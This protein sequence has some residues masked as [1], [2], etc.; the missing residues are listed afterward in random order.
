M[1]MHVKVSTSAYQSRQLMHKS[2]LSKVD[3]APNASALDLWIAALACDKQHLSQAWVSQWQISASRITFFD[4]EGRAVSVISSE[5]SSK[6]A[7]NG[8]KMINKPCG[9]RTETDWTLLGK[10]NAFS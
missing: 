8:R 10:I 2:S 3:L 4:V 9:I 6:S 1:K 5:V 7:R